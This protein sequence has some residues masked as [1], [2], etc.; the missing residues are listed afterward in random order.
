M[1]E[2]STVFV[3]TL[4]AAFFGATPA[5]AGFLDLTKLISGSTASFVGTLDGVTVNGTLAAT[6]GYFRINPTGPNYG[7]STTNDSSPQYSYSS[8]YTPTQAKTDKIGYLLFGASSGTAQLVIDFSKAITNPVWQVANLDSMQYDFKP[9]TGLTGLTLLSGNG[10]G[11]DGLAVN[12]L[13]IVDANPST[14]AD[15]TPTTPPPLTGGRSAYGS[16]QL[17]GTFTSLTIDFEFNPNT[18]YGNGDAGSFTLSSAP[19]VN[20]VPEP[21]SL[22]LMIVGLA[23]MFGSARRRRRPLAA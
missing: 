23:G 11:G 5:R 1:R 4:L 12:G 13:L 3:G 18:P 16:V 19:A 9:T 2:I 14:L 20:A 10:G 17:D 8:V 21:A 22:T 6:T 7:D 15:V